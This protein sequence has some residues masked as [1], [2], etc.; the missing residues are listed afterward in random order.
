M[1][2]NH[3]SISQTAESYKSFLK[4][5]EI[6]ILLFL[7]AI[8]SYGQAPLPD[9]ASHKPTTDSII[10]LYKNAMKENL[11][12]YNGREYLYSGHNAKGFP[13]FKSENM[14]TGFCYVR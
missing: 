14:L 11:R 4:R 2:V 3:K 5:T 12:L 8:L 10:A 1:L 6:V 7:P 9:S 13:Y